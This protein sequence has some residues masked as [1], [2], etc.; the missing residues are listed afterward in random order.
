MF[1]H[2]NNEKYLRRALNPRIDQYAQV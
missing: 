1:L 2:K